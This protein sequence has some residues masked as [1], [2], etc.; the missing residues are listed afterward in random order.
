MIDVRGKP[1]EIINET[2]RYVHR[3]TH[4]PHCMSQYMASGWG[5]RLRAVIDGTVVEA[6]DRNFYTLFKMYFL[7]DS[8][9]V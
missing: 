5:K 8:L 4:I 7:F 9:S 3:D 2:E 1:R 6:W